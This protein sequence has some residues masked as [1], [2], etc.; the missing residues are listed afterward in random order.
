MSQWKTIGNATSRFTRVA[1]S[2]SR[3]TRSR[4]GSVT[5]TFANCQDKN[6]LLMNHSLNR[7]Q[8]IRQTAA[9]T[10]AWLI[11]VRADARRL[12]PNDKLN[13]GMIGVAN[14]AGDDL[15]EV[16]TENIVALCDIVD[17]YLAPVRETYP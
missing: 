9:V 6:S 16:S 7:R 12:S 1:R 11:D 5:F 17:D 13:I 2:N 3:H 15:R 4:S 14:R 10:G 8:F